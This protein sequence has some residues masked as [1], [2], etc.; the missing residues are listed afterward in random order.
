MGLY[1]PCGGFRIAGHDVV[2]A[3]SG[4]AVAGAVGTGLPVRDISPGADFDAIFPQV[5]TVEERAKRMRERGR[6]ISH[7][8]VTPEVILEKFSRVADLMAEGTLEFARAWRPDL[9]VYSRLQGTALLTA[10]ALGIPAI[11]NGFTFLREGALPERFLP[12]LAPTYERLGIPVELPEVT[13]LYFAPEHMMYGEGQGLTMRFVP[14]HGGGAVP[15]WLARPRQRPRFSVTLGTV[16]PHIAGVGTLDRLLAAAR[17]MDAEFVLALGDKVDLSTLGPLPEN[18]RAVGWTPLN[19]LLDNSDGVIHHGGAN[20]TLASAQAGVPQLVMPHGA[21]NWINADIVTRCGIGLNR[22]P[23]ELDTAALRTLITD[24]GIRT[25]ADRVS[26]EL[27]AEP[28][29]EQLVPRLV[30]LARPR[31]RS[32]G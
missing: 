7:S 4:P 15:D 30:D 13:S 9:I 1:V 16:V 20:T 27:A 17:E 11:E 21:D 31:A 3:T 22:E 14:F 25:A 28:G 12:H 32:A 10:R 19:L 5:G 8:G 23:E 18:V 24:G 6:A 29:P 2:I 26:A